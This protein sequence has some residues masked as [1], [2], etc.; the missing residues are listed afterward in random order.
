[1]NV[2]IVKFLVLLPFLML[3]FQ[4]A[5]SFPV[6]QQ[7]EEQIEQAPVEQQLNSEE[8]ALL[9]FLVEKHPHLLMKLFDNIKSSQNMQQ[10]P[11]VEESSGSNNEM[12]FNRERRR[13]N[14]FKNIYS[15]CRVQKRKGKD[16]CLYLANLYQN[17]KG[18]HGI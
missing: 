3:I 13:L 14:V 2:S 8:N 4:A 17:V 6:E 9:H 1:M 10:Q 16:L 15:Q 18:L 11:S 5:H 7:N 12:G